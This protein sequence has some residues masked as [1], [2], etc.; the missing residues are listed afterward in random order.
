MR[1]AKKKTRYTTKNLRERIERAVGVAEAFL[2]GGVANFMG[3]YW[4]VGTAT[5]LTFSEQFYLSL[6][7]RKPFADAVQKAREAVNAKKSADW[8]DYIQY[9]NVEFPLRFR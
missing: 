1:R 2:R 7:N 3:T 9:G 8:A 5:A 6:L 4:P